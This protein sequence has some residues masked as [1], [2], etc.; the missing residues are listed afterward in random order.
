MDRIIE[1]LGIMQDSWPIATI[2]IV[3]IGALSLNWNISRITRAEKVKERWRLDNTAE[4]ARINRKEIAVSDH[5]RRSA[6]D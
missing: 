3:L 1:V 2:T 5:N 6:G 4:I